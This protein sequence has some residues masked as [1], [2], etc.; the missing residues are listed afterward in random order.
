MQIIENILRV[1]RIFTK[2]IDEDSTTKKCLNRTI[3]DGDI[4][5]H[6]GPINKVV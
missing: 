5:I 3:E 2:T 6:L 4:S 1:A